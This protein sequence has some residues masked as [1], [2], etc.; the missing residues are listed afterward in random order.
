MEKIK[1]LTDSCSD[2]KTELLEKYDIDYLRMET[3]SDGKSS[4]ALITWSDEEAHSFFDRIRNGEHITTAQVPASEFMEGFKKYLDEGYDIIYIACSSKQSGSVNTGTVVAKKLLEDYPDRKI[5][6]IDSLNSSI[7]IGMLAFE[8]SDMVKAGKTV[9][10]I[11]EWVLSHRNNVNQFVTVHTLE[12]LKRAGRVKGPAAF[13]GNLFGVKPIII[14]DAQGTQTPIK[15]AKGRNNSFR[16]MVAL[17]KE[18]IVEPE[19]QTI[20]V[21]HCDCAKE[22]VDEMC[23]M[24][25]EEIP[26]KDISVGFIGPIIGASVGPDAMAVFAFGNEVTYIAGETK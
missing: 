11:S 15:K 17:L 24:I 19:K 7:G 22:E 14:S 3:V 8:A 10:E 4:H 9:E 12:Y 25:R 16:E 5:V 26:C 18:S 13:F 6:C 1:I 20:Y 2:I 23:A 21:A